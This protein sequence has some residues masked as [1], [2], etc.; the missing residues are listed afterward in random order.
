MRI[1]IF[2][3]FN[4]LKIDSKFDVESFIDKCPK[5]LTGADFYSITNRAR[6]HALKRIIS[7]LELQNKNANDYDEVIEITEN[8]FIKV[9]DNF[10]PTLDES[11][12]AYYE[13]YFINNSDG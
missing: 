8:D 10:V 7:L 4:R 9:L 5:N 13:K 3:N 2:Y 12:L 11:S 1:K 6:Q